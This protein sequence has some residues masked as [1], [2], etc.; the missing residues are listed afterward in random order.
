MKLKENFGC[1]CVCVL[2]PKNLYWLNYEQIE[3][4]KNEQKKKQTKPALCSKSHLQRQQLQTRMLMQDYAKFS[5]M[6][7]VIVVVIG[8]FT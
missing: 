6:I 3:F 4:E 8:I 5:I 7:F 2:T 1:V